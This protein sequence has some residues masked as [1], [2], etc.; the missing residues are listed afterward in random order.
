M[1][2]K[3][4]CNQLLFVMKVLKHLKKAY[5]FFKNTQNSL[6]DSADVVR[7]MI[8]IVEGLSTEGPFHALVKVAIDLVEGERSLMSQY[9]YNGG[10]E[11]L[12]R[13]FKM[14]SFIVEF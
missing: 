13:S 7:I 10:K 1:I 14:R 8:E 2:C 12:P 9:L 6:G 3:K 4:F 11:S 5:N